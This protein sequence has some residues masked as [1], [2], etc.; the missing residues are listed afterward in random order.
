MDLWTA[1]IAPSDEQNTHEIC[2]GFWTLPPFTSAVIRVFSL[3]VTLEVPAQM[4]GLILSQQILSKAGRKGFPYHNPGLFGEVH[5][6]YQ[7]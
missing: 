7:H 5:Q 4:L 6:D 3:S 2:T 1:E